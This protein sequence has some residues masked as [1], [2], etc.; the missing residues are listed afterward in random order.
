MIKY[1]RRAWEHLS[2]NEKISFFV[3][4]AAGIFFILVFGMNYPSY[5]AASD[6]HQYLMGAEMLSHG[7]ARANA[8]EWVCDSRAL[9]NGE[10][11]SRYPVGRSLAILPFVGGDLS[12]IFLSGLLIHLLNYI[13]FILILRR[14]KL[15]PWYALLYL[16]YPAFQ[17]ESRTLYPELG[18]LTFFLTGYYFWLSNKVRDTFLAGVALGLSLFLRLDAGLGFGAFLVQAA[19][20]DR[21]RIIPLVSG[22]ILGIIPLL[23][24]NQ[25][26]YGNF[27]QTNYGSGVDLTSLGRHGLEYKIPEFITAWFVVILVM[28]LSLFSLIS[29]KRKDRWLFAALTLATIL[30][31]VRFYEFWAH[32]TSIA[33]IFTVR[34]RYYIPLLGM[35]MIPTIA[36]YEEGRIK[37]MT[38]LSTHPKWTAI[39]AA[40]VVLT[41]LLIAGGTIVAQTQ[42]QKL[43]DS[44]AA[45]LETIQ[46]NIPAGASVIGSA[47]DCIYFTPFFE[48]KN[49]Q[50]VTNVDGNAP[51]E[52]D[53]YVLDISYATQTGNDTARQDV[54]DAERQKIKDFIAARKDELVQVLQ[55]KGTSTIT[56][57]KTK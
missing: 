22:F 17:W 49:Y 26:A 14:M 51:L 32:G 37:I 30:F 25:W 2:R 19:A 15:P 46:M 50:K 53:T 16:F 34:L 6:E 7:T 24:F 57:W 8:D 23:A 10:N 42:H 45:V 3:L 36:F 21:K 41:I 28:P 33:Q 13:I 27:L 11:V 12:W 4:A 44:R 56:I 9:G 35:L 40:G 1:I 39:R 5:F 54:V 47:D 31:F 38:R 18:V 48:M 55:Y 20:N 43:L 52:N 29:S